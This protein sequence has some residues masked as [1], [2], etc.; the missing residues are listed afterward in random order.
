LFGYCDSE[1]DVL[2]YQGQE[3]DVV[4]MDEATQF[5]EFQ[6]STLT[7]SL[8]GVNS[9][10]KRF[11]LTCNPG[12]VGH[13]WV[14][15]LFVDRQ[16]RGA[17][18]AA[19]YA[20][21]AA[22]VYDNAALAKSDPG[23][24]SLLENLPEAQRKAWLL[25]QWDVFE[26]QYFPEF[27]REVHVCS[28]FAI[29]SHWRRYVTLDYGMDMLAALWIAVDEEGRA[30]VY[31]EL[32]EG[33]D[34]QKGENGGGHIIS[35]AARRLREVNNN[36]AIAAWLAPP[37][38]WNRRQETGKSAAQLF[39]EH[40]VSLTKTGNDRV[41][42]WLAV[43][44]WLAQESDPMQEGKSRPRLRIFSA[45]SNLVRTLPSLRYSEHNPEDAATQPHEMTHAPDALRGFCTYWSR[46]AD[47]PRTKAL[48]TLQRN[49]KMREPHKSSLGKGE[50]YHVL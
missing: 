47:A 31:K 15:R 39:Y 13:A 34:N 35:A 10:P 25:G 2:Q 11:Y 43:R 9:H 8:R 21:I 12:G 23:Y 48:D 32:Y 29:P 17:E 22:N 40:G 50:S 45:C 42:G 41:A 28:P 7:A 4:F 37:D 5:T 33:R 1:S 49:F 27:Q 16:Y 44:E 38:L 18:Q 14:K 6:F 36:D 26:G 46:A 20:F 3:Y 19:D 24:V 30:V